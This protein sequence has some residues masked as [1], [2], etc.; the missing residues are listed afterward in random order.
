[1]MNVNE[2]F[3][4]IQGESTHAG[5]P[6]IFIRLTGCNLRCRYCDTTYAYKI[7]RAYGIQTIIEQI[8]SYQCNLVEITGGEPLL[9]KKTP[10][11][12]RQLTAY[13]YEVLVETNGSQNID[14]LHVPVKRILD[15]K[16]P[17]SG[18]TD[19]MDQKNYHRLRSGDELKFVLSDKN[20]YLWAKSV[21][22]RHKIPN[23]IPILFSPVLER[24][25][26]KKLA[27]WILRDRLNVRLQLQLHKIIWT[28]SE[29]GK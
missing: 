17:G 18:E 3:Y 7:G 13:G 28:D 19:Q 12:C 10:E 4:S 8:K 15:M 27:A 25:E 1:M 6:C 21:I 2:I 16:C 26:P 11:L 20:D 14:C 23:E 9:Q 22:S 24:L 5:K 29:R